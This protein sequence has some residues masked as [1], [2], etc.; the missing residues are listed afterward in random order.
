MA[1]VG[2]KVFA[3]DQVKMRSLG[4]VLT[5]WD[6]GPYRKGSGRRHTQRDGPG[7]TR[8]GD[9]HLHAQ[10]RGLRRTSPAHTW[11]WDSSLRLGEINAVDWG[12]CL[13][14]CL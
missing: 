1:L 12:P 13:G 6:W 11:V 5:P 3:D 14:L 10:E 8:G 9:G 4:W 7:R 2:N